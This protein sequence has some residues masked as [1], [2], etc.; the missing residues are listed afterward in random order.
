MVFPGSHKRRP[1]IDCTTN[2][3]LGRFLANFRI[4]QSQVKV[5]N[6]D[7]RGGGKL[8]KQDISLLQCEV[9]QEDSKILQSASRLFKSIADLSIGGQTAGEY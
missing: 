6:I 1:T 8:G 2:E 9:H 7:S 4:S 3:T 5:I